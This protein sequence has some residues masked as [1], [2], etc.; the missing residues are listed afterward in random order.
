[1]DRRDVLAVLERNPTAWLGLV[2]VLCSRL[3]QTDQHLVEVALLGLPQRL[4]KTLLRII[5]APRRQTANRNELR[6][7]QYELAN[8]VGASRESVNKCL[9][10]WQRAGIIRMEKR[11]IKIADRAALEAMSEPE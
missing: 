11:A 6:L 7:S 1:L 4:A 3:R 5:D 8:L 2:E 10:E 9:H